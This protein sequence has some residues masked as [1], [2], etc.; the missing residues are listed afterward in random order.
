MKL[1]EELK[2]LNEIDELVPVKGRNEIE[3]VDDDLNAKL[4][5]KIDIIADALAH[6]FEQEG[7]ELDAKLIA[8][9]IKT[10]G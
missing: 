4:L 10:E 1:Y 6:A 5:K 8:D 3:I 9:D 2:K 7:L